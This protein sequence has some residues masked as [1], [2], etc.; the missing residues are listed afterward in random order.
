[1]F[2]EYISKITF[3]QREGS[4]V[5]NIVEFNQSFVGVLNRNLQSR[6]MVAPMFESMPDCLQ[7]LTQTGCCIGLL[8]IF[9]QFIPG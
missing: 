9:D 3:W 4:P 7:F 1:M 8:V 6:D 2:F 5:S